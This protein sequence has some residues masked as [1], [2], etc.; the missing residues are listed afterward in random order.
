MPIYEYECQKC[1]NINEVLAQRGESP[2][3][4]PEC[5]NAEVRKAFSKFAVSTGVCSSIDSCERNPQSR[6]SACPAG[7]CPGMAGAGE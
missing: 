2:P 1:G 6:P 4:C 7:K 3:A 5:G